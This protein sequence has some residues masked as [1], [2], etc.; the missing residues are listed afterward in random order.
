MRE[1]GGAPS[2]GEPPCWR[3]RRPALR[4]LHYETHPLHRT[5]TAGKQAAGSINRRDPRSLSIA[6]TSVMGR[7][8]LSL[9][10]VLAALAL[11]TGGCVQTSMLP[12]QQLEGDETVA[13][14]SL[15][16]PGFLY[17]PRANAQFTAGLGG[18]DLSL[19]VSGPPLGAGLAGR[20]YLTPR[21]NA[22]AQVQTARGF[23]QE[24]GASLAM[25]GLQEVPT[26]DDVWYLGGQ[27][28]AIVGSP[29]LDLDGSEE[30]TPQ[31]YP[32]V[33]ATLGLGPFEVGS[34]WQIQVE[35]EGNAPITPGNE[36]PPLPATRLS[37]GFFYLGD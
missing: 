19:N 2:E 18:G 13:A 31:T 14:V 26:G 16:E 29:V 33:G 24:H 37:I 8:P 21:L 11:L 7:W 1:N 35:L 5:Q 15:D 27:A 12:A 28:G 17:I 30:D 22:E 34:S 9:F 32:V 4:T 20:Y 25:V 3:E 23:D 36:E 6:P 10:G